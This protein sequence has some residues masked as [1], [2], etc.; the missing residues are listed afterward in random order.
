MDAQLARATDILLERSV[1]IK[2]R[3]ESKTS[4]PREEFEKLL[5]PDQLA[6]KLYDHVFATEPDRRIKVAIIDNGADKIRS[7]IGSMIEK[8]ISYV[9][10][11]LLGEA[12]RPWWMVADA[13]GTQMA[14]LIGQINPYC[15]LYIARV[16]KGRADID[17]KKAA[18][19]IHW[20]VEQK[21]DIIS[22]S[23]VTKKN[24]E[25]LEK[26]VKEAAQTDKGRRPTLMFCSTADEGAFGG[27]AYPVDYKEH[28]VSV[29]AT[30]SWGGLTSKTD[31]H[32]RVDVSIPG[33]D[34]EASA[35]F[36][37][38]NVGSTVSGSSVATALAVGI[39]SLALLL[40]RTYNDGSEDELS[41]FYTRKGI[42]RVF[43]RMEASK[44]GVQL[45]HLFLRDP[46]EPSNIHGTMAST[47]KIKKFL[48]PP[49]LAG[50]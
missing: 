8:G 15:R 26:A 24:E 46:V 19:A 17:P 31:R 34:L 41:S 21:V 6:L 16:G 23:W 25:E 30:D 47:W 44:G 45:Q 4:I 28:V 13:H 9:S 33:E 48:E 32:T 10:S 50:T 43:D 12:P 3:H 20:A 27:P 38:G 49:E 5:P 42:M 36:Y 2:H 37:L 40:L 22:M 18:K 11:D 1:K 39:A 14:S 7:P 35:P 29:S